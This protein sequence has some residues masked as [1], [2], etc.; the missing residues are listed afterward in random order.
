MEVPPSPAECP[1]LAGPKGAVGRVE[2][3]AGAAQAEGGGEAEERG[4]V[5][6]GAEGEASA[7]DRPVEEE[8]NRNTTHSGEEEVREDTSQYRPPKNRRRLLRDRQ[9]HQ[10]DSNPKARG[11]AQSDPTKIPSI[12][13][14][15][16]GQSQSLV[17]RI[18]PKEADGEAD[19]I[20]AGFGE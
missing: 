1:S 15:P 7:E 4:V 14:S 19:P 10:E 13:T 11:I 6:D 16:Q 17:L 12:A 8:L 2:G 20:V 3:G 9:D 5:R 18:E